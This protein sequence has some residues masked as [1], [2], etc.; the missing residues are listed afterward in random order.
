M[1]PPAQRLPPARRAEASCGGGRTAQRRAATLG[2]KEKDFST[3]K[4]VAPLPNSHHSD[5]RIPQS[6]LASS[7]SW[8]LSPRSIPPL[9]PPADRAAAQTDILKANIEWC[10]VLAKTDSRGFFVKTIPFFLQ[11]ESFEFGP[12]RMVGRQKRFFSVQDRR[13]VISGVIDLALLARGKVDRDGVAQ[14]RM[15]I[16]E[17]V[18][19]GQKGDLQFVGAEFQDVVGGTDI[20]RRHQTSQERVER[21]AEV[22]VIARHVNGRM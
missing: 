19:V 12:A 22:R 1:R 11:R 5:V 20:E 3:L 21:I 16:F 10:P 14:D 2:N 8:R 18:E 13:V 4:A 15:R 6:Q 9:P 17:K 7:G